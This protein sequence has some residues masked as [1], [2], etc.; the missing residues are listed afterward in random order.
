M[1]G[2]SDA[3]TD[4]ATLAAAYLGGTRWRSL[5]EVGRVDV[6]AASAVDRLD[7]LFAAGA[8]PFAGTVF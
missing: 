6:S 8:L 1:T 3:T 2:K 4:V 7:G 5:A